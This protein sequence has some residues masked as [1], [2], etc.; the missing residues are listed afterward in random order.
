ML[1][2]QALTWPI[3]GN[4]ERRGGGD[5]GDDDDSIR[6]SVGGGERAGTQ[7]WLGRV[8]RQSGQSGV[9]GEVGG[10]TNASLRESGTRT[11]LREGEGGG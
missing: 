11:S 3:H 1:D 5:G 6:M 8:T 10:R 9:G 7:P 2:V 4:R